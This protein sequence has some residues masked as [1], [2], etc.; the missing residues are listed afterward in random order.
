MG[1]IADMIIDGFLDEETGE[2][3]DGDAPGYPRR[4]RDMVWERTRHIRKELALLIKKK[5]AA[6]TTEKQ[7]NHAVNEARRE[8]NLKYGKNWRAG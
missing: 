4:I 8:I 6:C 2:Y 7:K 3:I 5:Q 1:E